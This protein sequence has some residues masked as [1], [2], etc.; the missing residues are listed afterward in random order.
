MQRIGKLSSKALAFC[1]FTGV[2]LSHMSVVGMEQKDV[3]TDVKNFAQGENER[4]IDTVTAEEFS[5]RVQKNI[6]TP[7]DIFV[8]FPKNVDQVNQFAQLAIENTKKAYDKLLAIPAEERT[9]ENTARAYDKMRRDLTVVY[10]IIIRLAGLHP[11]EAMR[12]ACWDATDQ[13]YPCF[14]RIFFDKKLYE[15]FSVVT[16]KYLTDKVYIDSLSPSDRMYLEESM[17][18]FEREGLNLPDD[19]L[20]KVKDL[21]KEIT[22][23]SNN[24]RKNISKDESPIKVEE[25]ELD[26]VDPEFVKSLKKDDQGKLI[27]PCDDNFFRKILDNCSCEQTR[28]KMFYANKNRAYQQND[29]L[30]RSLIAKRHEL[31]QLLGYETFAA[32][33]FAKTMAKTPERAESFLLDLISKCI[34]RAQKEENIWA[35]D[36]P[37]GVVRNKQGCLDLWSRRFVMSHYKKQNFNID[38]R[39]LSKYFP[40]EKTVESIFALC[41]KFFGFTFS[42]TTPQWAWHPDVRLIQINDAVSGQLHGY[43]FLDLYHRESKDGTSA[44]RLIPTLK[45]ASG[46]KTPYVG[47]IVANFPQPVEGNGPALLN[48]DD[49]E[50]FFHELGHA[51]HEMF[52]STDLYEYTGFSVASD[53]SEVPSQMLE[54]WVYDADVLRQISSHVTT[55]E[56][57]PQNLIDKKIE[58][59][60]FD[61]CGSALHQGILALYALKLFSSGASVDPHALWLELFTK[62][63]PHLQH[64]S[65]VHP[66]ASTVHFGYKDYSCKLYNYLWSDVFAFDIF[67]KVKEQGFFSADAG[68]ELIDKILSKGGAVDPNVLLEDY[69]G[70]KPNSDAFLKSLGD[71]E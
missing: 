62:Y 56:P 28:K 15:A 32:L 57:L 10:N 24:F 3:L 46:E 63:Q 44:S 49:V 1:F 21:Q 23:I 22:T 33:D 54:K 5:Q 34:S 66:Y 17:S 42:I 14:H 47:L 51:M 4:K 61:S 52:G 36:L 41:Q 35:K 31:A 60:Q 39:E 45:L 38:E 37:E 58:L 29:A 64:E 50:T 43:I 7:D 26:G 71:I 48:F 27:V 59:K 18:D 25:Q 11:D 9:F 70:R 19:Q 40:V 20:Q 8:L 6:Q 16:S 69:L 2:T 67:S 30:L 68:R 12:E 13:F 55:N 65:N 53:F